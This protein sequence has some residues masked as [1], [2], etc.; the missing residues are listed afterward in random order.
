MKKNLKREIS[1]AINESLK[2]IEINEAY[3]T[4][5]KKF[6]L[7]TSY[8]SDTAKRAS[9]KEFEEFVAALNR[10]SAE[11]DG[12]DRTL[13]GNK[14]SKFRSLKIDETH[15]MN[16]AFLRALHFENIDSL[17]SSITMDTMAFIR[18]ERDFGSFDDWQKDFIACCMSSRD[19]YAVLGYSM[20]LKRYMNFVID[21]EAENVPVGMIPIIVLDVNT[22]AYSQD[23]P[24]KRREYIHA[25]M[26][27]FDWA[28]IEKRLRK[29]EKIANL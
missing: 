4:K 11:L 21:N 2:G 25:M 18:L 22:A 8:L 16:A 27:E 26:K 23:Y 28:K 12:A 6:D 29:A 9:Q 13:A 5:P 24:G 1:Q 15:C 19:G 17:N 3:V 20:F 14:S 10:V 7:R